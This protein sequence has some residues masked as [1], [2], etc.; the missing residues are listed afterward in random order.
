MRK[1]L[2]EN[3]GYIIVAKKILNLPITKIGT[4]VKKIKN[5]MINKKTLPLK[6]VIEKA[7]WE[8]R[9]RDY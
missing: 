2:L 4:N 8:W 1:S 9:F 6:C 3:D 5:N 7:M